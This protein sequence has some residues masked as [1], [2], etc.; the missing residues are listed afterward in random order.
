MSLRHLTSSSGSAYGLLVLA[1]LFW[2]GNVVAVRHSVG[3]ASPMALA[4]LRWVVV[5][6]LLAPVAAPRCAAAA[7]LRAHWRAVVW[8]GA[9][10]LTVPNL[11]VFTAAQT[12]SALNMAIFLGATP[13]FVF[14]GALLWHR[15]PSGPL[16]VI[17][18][19]A[20]LAGVALAA[21]RGDMGRVGGLDLHLGDVFVLLSCVT[22]AAYQ[23]SLRDTPPLPPLVLFYAM[24]L[25]AFAVSLPV[26][27]AEAWVGRAFWPTGDGWVV[28]VYVG[29]FPTLLSSFFMMRGIQLIGPRRASLFINLVPV[30]ASLFAVLLLNEAVEAFHLAAVGLVLC[31]IVLSEVAARRHLALRAGGAAGK[32]ADAI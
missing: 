27:A 10:G 3:N 16:Q 7:A 25:V 9:F 28:I 22:G 20:T 6:L 19:M 12:T 31:G 1:A 2:G 13:A 11:L 15:S 4:C 32:R 18:M 17:G 23:L 29:L 21:V 14:L 8:M 26:A 24:A 30:F 5:L